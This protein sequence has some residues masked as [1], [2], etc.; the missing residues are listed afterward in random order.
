ML[1]VD[2]GAYSVK[3][4]LTRK[5]G[6]NF[7]PVFLGEMLFAPQSLSEGEIR[8]KSILVD[9]LRRFWQRN[10]LP[11]EVVASFYHPRMVVQNISLPEMPDEEIE[12]ALRWEASSIITGEDSFQIGW[13]TLEKKEGQQK[14]LFAA[15]PS[16]IVEEYLDVF[17]QV[18]LE[19]EAFEPQTLSLLRGF[20]S[21]YPDLVD[22]SFSIVDLGFAK[23]GIL[24]FSTGK[25]VFSRYFNWG[26]G[27]VWDYLGENFELLPAEIMEL[28]DRSTKEEDAPYQMQE[29]LSEA[30]KELITELRRSLSFLQSE[31]GSDSNQKLF[32]SGGGA[33]IS[34]LRQILIE[35]LPVAIGEIPPLVVK[36]EEFPAEVYLGALGA[37]LWS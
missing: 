17:R 31:F 6:E 33:R 30:S 24:Y 25:L 35:S 11:R 28:F 29:A 18:R 36:K 16:L 4:C 14:I 15:S 8:D 7:E 9:N 22:S 13:Q 19:V 5:K 3:F 21:L 23:G 10:R 26:L 34:F 12:N 37:S 27:K 1:G 32:L 2:L 20:L